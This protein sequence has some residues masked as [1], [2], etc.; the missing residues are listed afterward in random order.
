MEARYGS[1]MNNENCI[2]GT[3]LDPRYKH[4]AF[5]G[6]TQSSVRHK[7]AVEELLINKYYISV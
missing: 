4:S 5:K 2:L 7:D 3:Y 1:Y 6:E